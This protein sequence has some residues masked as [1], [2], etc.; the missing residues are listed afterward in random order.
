MGDS[1]FWNELWGLVHIDQSGV[2]HKHLSLFL[3]YYI[4]H[5]KRCFIG[6]SKHR[7]E[8]DAQPSI[9][10]EILG[11]L[12]ADETVSSVWYIFTIETK[13]KE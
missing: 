10:D 11:V 12:I 8:R 5:K 13:T 7:E 9:F 6:I 3:K 1:W 2:A 4:K